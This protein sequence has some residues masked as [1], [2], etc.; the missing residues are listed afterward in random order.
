MWIS[1]QFSGLLKSLALAIAIGLIYI[2]GD[3]IKEKKGE[4]GYRIFLLIV[5]VSIA[6][7]FTVWVGG[8]VIMGLNNLFHQTN[9]WV[10]LPT[11]IVLA[12]V[13]ILWI[14]SKVR[15]IKGTGRSDYL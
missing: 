11:A 2:L 6:I 4:P 7:I 12:I 1:D 3:R 8:I 13:P 9:I 5:K 14:I 15:Q 10:F